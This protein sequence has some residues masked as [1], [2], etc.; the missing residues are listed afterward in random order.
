AA[1]RRDRRARVLGVAAPVHGVQ[2]APGPRAPP[3][4]DARPRRALRD[5]PGRPGVANGIEVVLVPPGA[6]G[7]VETGERLALAE[8]RLDD[9]DA[10]AKEALELGLVPLHGG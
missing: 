10:H 5:V 2:L 1:R 6:A 4:D 3:P 7:G 8:I 9:A